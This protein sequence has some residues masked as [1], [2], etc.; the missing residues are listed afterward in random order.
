VLIWNPSSAKKTCLQG[1]TTKQTNDK[2][3]GQLT[4]DDAWAG[5]HEKDLV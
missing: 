5:F 1:Q 2:N 3:N 4:A